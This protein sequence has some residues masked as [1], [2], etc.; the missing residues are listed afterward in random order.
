MS[1]PPL[2]V[3]GSECCA[4]HLHNRNFEVHVLLDRDEEFLKGATAKQLH[5]LQATGVH[6]VN[7]SGN[8]YW[9]RLEHAGE[10]V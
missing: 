8:R 7:P 4:R 1:Q 9:V 10:Q 6:P 5:I 3:S 2:K